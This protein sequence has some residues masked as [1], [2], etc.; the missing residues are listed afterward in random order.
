MNRYQSHGHQSQYQ[1]GS[2]DLVLSNLV[3]ITSPE[4]MKE[5]ELELLAQLYEDVLLNK[6]PDRRLTVGDLKEWHRRWLGNV[7]RW[8]G[9][10]RSVNMSKDGFPFAA[11]AQIARLLVEF[12]H[13]CLTRWTPC[14][15]L[16]TDELLQA[17][18]Q[19]HVELILIHPF[20]E[21][22]GR[23]SR[24]L[25]DVMVVQAGRKPLDYSA[26]EANRE[27]YIG[28]IQ[29]GSGRNYGPMRYWFEQAMGF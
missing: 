19:T 6:L 11:A 7:Y 26:W 4:D 24:L 8:A 16:S 3:G 10:D 2:G 18:A 13:D 28:A 15:A 23:L 5:L 9:Q 14:D 29:Q 25:A 12:E 1:P 20:R 17:L 22:N 27:A 21:G